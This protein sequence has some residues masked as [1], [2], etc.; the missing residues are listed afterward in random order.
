M[1]KRQRSDLRG[2]KG[3]IAS[4]QWPIR[5]WLEPLRI[6]EDAESCRIFLIGPR[7]FH[8]RHCY[9]KCAGVWDVRQL[10]RVLGGRPST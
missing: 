5:K 7:Q 6:L 1:P 3:A 9:L 4:D 8:R 10:E 2:E